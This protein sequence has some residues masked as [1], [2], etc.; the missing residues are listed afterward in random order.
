[1]DDIIVINR[2]IRLKEVTELTGFAKSFIYKQIRMGNFPAPVRIGS[3]SARWEL[4]KVL[5]WIKQHKPS[6]L[7]AA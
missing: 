5:A 4:H 3:R 1:M 7:V 2:L 6:S